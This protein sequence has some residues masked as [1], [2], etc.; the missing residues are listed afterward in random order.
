MVIMRLDARAA[1]GK[2]RGLREVLASGSARM[3]WRIS[4]G[5]AAAEA[6]TLLV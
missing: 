1:Q 6:A 4:V 5:E 2:A 3:P